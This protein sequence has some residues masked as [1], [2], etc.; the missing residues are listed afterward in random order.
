MMFPKAFGSWC[1]FWLLT[2]DDPAHRGHL[3]IDA[4]EY[5]GLA[6]KRGHHHTIHRW[7]PDEPKG[8]QYVGDYTGMDAI[9]DF[10][11]HR[12]GIDLRGIAQVDGEPAIVITMDRKEVGR[13]APD[14]DFFT[15]E[16]YFLLTLSVNPKDTKWDFPQ[17]MLV[18]YVRVWE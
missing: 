3:E 6:D 2:K 12:Y 7:G 18:D 11:M 13:I 14:A 9:A 16:F 8:H 17:R 15:R 10:K 5:Y 4:I 1:A